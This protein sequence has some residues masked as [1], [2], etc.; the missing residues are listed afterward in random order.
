MDG[1]FEDLFNLR[2]KVATGGRLNAA[3]AAG[4]APKDATGPYVLNATPSRDASGAVKWVRV[5]GRVAVR[6]Q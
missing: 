6:T 4:A 3:A 5:V 1:Y 2:G